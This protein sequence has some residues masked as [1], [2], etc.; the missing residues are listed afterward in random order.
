MWNSVPKSEAL[1]N[2]CRFASIAAVAGSEDGKGSISSAYSTPAGLYDRCIALAEIH[3]LASQRPVYAALSDR[4]LGYCR[5]QDQQLTTKLFWNCLT[6]S[7]HHG[8]LFAV[9]CIKASQ[10]LK[11]KYDLREC[12]RLM[13]DAVGLANSPMESWH[14]AKPR[15]T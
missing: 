15:M 7:V 6:F 3:N 9:A 5:L 11:A 14:H 13:L 8:V 2:N 1:G 4:G 12:A 10:V